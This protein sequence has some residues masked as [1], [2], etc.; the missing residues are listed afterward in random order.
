MIKL[1]LS[2]SEVD[3]GGG[4]S[5]VAIPQILIVP[6]YNMQYYCSAW[7]ANALKYVTIVIYS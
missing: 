5:G 7:F 1:N 3:L 6:T 2:K 4:D